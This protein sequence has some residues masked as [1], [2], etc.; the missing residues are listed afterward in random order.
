MTHFGNGDK[1]NRINVN[2]V[3]GMSVKSSFKKNVYLEAGLMASI[4]IQH[5]CCGTIITL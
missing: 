1:P 2:S 5:I 4:S 3:V